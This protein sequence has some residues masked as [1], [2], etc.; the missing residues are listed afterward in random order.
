MT[1]PLRSVTRRGWIALILFALGVL[2]LGPAPSYDSY[3]HP[4][5]DYAE[6]LRRVEALRQDDTP[7]IAP[8][9]RTE[10]LT[11]GVRTRRIVVLLHGLTNCPAQF[12]S[13]GR[14]AFRRGANVLIPRLPRHG[15]ANRMTRALSGLRA[16]EMCAFTDR[17]LDAADGLGDSV[18]VVGLSVGGVMAA[19]AAQ[20]RPDVDRAVLVA[21]M[22]GAAMVPP[23][24]TGVAARAFGL[25]PNLFVWW[26]E[27]ARERLAGPQH[28]YPRFATRAV[29]ATLRLAAAVEAEANRRPPAFRSAALVT[30][31]GDHA[32]SNA[33]AEELLRRWRA[34]GA[35]AL[36]TFSFPRSLHLNH[37]IVDPEQVGADPSRTYPLLMRLIDS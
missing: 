37:D 3:A 2:L 26:D 11:H 19:W 36:E 14:L 6:G 20:E 30:I 7:D 28:V 22:L 32:V 34:H 35:R 33:A 27:H 24:V 18:T 15:Q 10:L 25:L 4:A 29:A 9:C 17:V 31:D 1:R 21:P 8:E 16:S 5:H 12:D 13:I 23:G